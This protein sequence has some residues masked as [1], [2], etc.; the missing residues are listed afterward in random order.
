MASCSPSAAAAQGGPATSSSPIDTPIAPVQPAAWA[1]AAGNTT[2][3]DSVSTKKNTILPGG[4]ELHPPAN[5]KKY[6]PERIKVLGR[7]FHKADIS[8]ALKDAGYGPGQSAVY[9]NLK[10]VE[11]DRY[12]GPLSDPNVAALIF[13]RISNVRTVSRKTIPVLTTACTINAASVLHLAAVAAAPCTINTASTLH[14]PM[15]P[16]TMACSTSAFISIEGC[17]SECSC[18]E[19]GISR[20]IP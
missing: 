1:A 17:S 14:P 20:P 5:G 15:A 8:K 19:L 12:V 10:G 16:A 6:T 18:C 4:Y 13:R 11:I 9:A 3:N 7:R 2:N